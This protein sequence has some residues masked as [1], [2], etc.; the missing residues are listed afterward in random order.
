MAT[1]PCVNGN[2]GRPEERTGIG[3]YQSMDEDVVVYIH[4]RA[5]LLPVV[6]PVLLPVLFH[7]LFHHGVTLAW[8]LL[9]INM[10]FCP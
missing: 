4:H 8:R 10:W 2:A 7:L 1:Y 9:G 3:A 5:A 6:L